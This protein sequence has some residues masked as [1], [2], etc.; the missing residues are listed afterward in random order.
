MAGRALSAS[1]YIYHQTEQGIDANPRMGRVQDEEHCSG[2]CGVMNGSLREPES[3]ANGAG[4]GRD[5]EALLW[6]RRDVGRASKV[7]EN[8]YPCGQRGPKRRKAGTSFVLCWWC[9]WS[10]REGRIRLRLF[11]ESGLSTN[12]S[13]W[14]PSWFARI[15]NVSTMLSCHL[16]RLVMNA[17]FAHR[18]RHGDG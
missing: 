7:S 14:I 12:F 17:Q 8:T 11:T 2:W 13:I 4:V 16:P 6:V 3:A 9:A 15:W 1:T 18:T 10:L 5:V